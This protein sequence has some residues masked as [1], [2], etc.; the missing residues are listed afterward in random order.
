MTE[1]RELYM[2]LGSVLYALAKTDGHLQSEETEMLATMLVNEP[3][4]ETV[5]E[6]FHVHDQYDVDI[7]EAYAYAFRRFATSRKDL[8]EET[9]KRFIQIAE[10]IADAYDGVSRKENEFIRRF[11]RDINRL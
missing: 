9:K 2:G 10:R 4:G 1:T 7:E 8:D 5:L 6:A 3:N 11:R